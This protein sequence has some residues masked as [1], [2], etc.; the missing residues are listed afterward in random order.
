MYLVIQFK[1]KH[2][3]LSFIFLLVVSSFTVLA[4]PVFKVDKAVFVFADAK[5]GEILYHLYKIKNEGNEPL[6]ITDF[7]VA[8]SC[9]KVDLPKKPILPNETY[10]LKL[11]FNT[12]GKSYLQDRTVILQTNTKRKSEKVRFKVFVIP[13]N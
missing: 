9:T 7:K 4:Q 8:C 3:K 2:M 6:I 11:S 10:E 5:E 1:I 12:E 13:K